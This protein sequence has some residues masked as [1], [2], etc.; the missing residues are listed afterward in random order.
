MPSP[1]PGMDPFLEDPY[2]FPDVH[3]ALATFLRDLLNRRLPNPYYAR[4]ELRPEVGIIDE[5][6]E[7]GPAK[8][9]V[10]DVL[11]LRQPQHPGRG[12]S[13]GVALAEPRA[14]VGARTEVS[15]WVELERLPHAKFRHAFVEIR[16]SQRSHKL[17]TLVEIL[18]PSSKR[19]GPDREAYQAKQ[20]EVLESDASLIEIDLLRAGRRILP[21]AHLEDGIRVLRCPYVVLVSRA[22]DRE[23]LSLGYIVFPIGQ[24]DPLPC[25]PVPLKQGE[26]EL[27]LDLQFIFNEVYD[28]GP[29]RRGAVDYAVPTQPPL[30]EEDATWAAGLAGSP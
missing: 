27:P 4:V 17:V 2:I 9:I 7:Q 22:W 24:R 11:V 1:F 15:A 10:P 20:R 5:D 8:R 6:D 23:N 30:S 13:G 3:Q 29:Y 16:D 26:A 25:I 21:N 19:R 12:D 14:I 18:S 28:G